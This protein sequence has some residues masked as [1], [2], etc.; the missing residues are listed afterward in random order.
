MAIVDMIK[1]YGSN[2]GES[3]MWNSVDMISE[4]LDKHLSE[5]ELCKLE[6]KLYHLLQGGHYNK[7]FA[8]EQMKKMYY[9]DTDGHRH[10]APYWTENEVSS[11]Y[12]EVKSS[13]GNY[14]L[15]DFEVALNMI[16]S[17][18]CMLLKKWF[19]NESGAE[20]LKRMVMLTV[21]WLKD[22]DNPFGDEKVWRY[23]NS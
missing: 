2:K 16:K 21:N 20:C 18:Y 5:E 1:K 22:E 17:D 11:V 23:F 4:A 12:S 6:K 15:Y 19:P 9:V 13:I 10:Y 8:E 3:Y 7:E 14:N